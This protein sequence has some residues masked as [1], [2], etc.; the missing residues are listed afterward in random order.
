MRVLLLVDESDASELTL[1]W[2]SGFLDKQSA[3]LLG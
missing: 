2:I 1:A 3:R